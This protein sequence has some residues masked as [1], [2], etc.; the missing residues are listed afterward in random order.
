MRKSNQ[1]H[2]SQMVRYAMQRYASAWSKR[3]LKAAEHWHFAAERA[4]C[5]ANTAVILRQCG[6]IVR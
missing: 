4:R 1:E 2:F 3:D 5:K 6:S